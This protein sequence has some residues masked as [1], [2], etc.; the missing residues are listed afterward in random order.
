[1]NGQHDVPLDRRKV[2][3]LF[4]VS[5][6]ALCIATPL[7]YSLTV[8]YTNWVE[9]ATGLVLIPNNK[10]WLWTYIISH[11]FIGVLQLAAGIL[12]LVAVF[13]IRKFLVDLGRKNQVN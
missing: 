10:A 13:K 7:I 1:M 2:L 8:L 9:T 4:Y 6:F 3:D 11:Y 12:L 5:V